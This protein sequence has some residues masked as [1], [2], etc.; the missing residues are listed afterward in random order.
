M[1]IYLLTIMALAGFVTFALIAPGEAVALAAR[2]KRRFRAYLIARHGADAYKRIEHELGREAER[3][4]I[5]D[6]RTAHFLKQQ[7]PH[8]VQEFGACH[9]DTILG[10]PTLI[11]ERG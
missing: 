8:I 6:E 5:T 11:E 3:R 9:A 7:R 2:L 10:E 4:G 1:S